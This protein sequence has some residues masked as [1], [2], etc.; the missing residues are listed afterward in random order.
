M[1]FQEDASPGTVM[2]V[3]VTA[4]PA[5]HNADIKQLTIF[6]LTVTIDRK[7]PVKK[8]DLENEDLQKENWPEKW[9]L[10]LIIGA[11]TF[12][13]LLVALIVIC[14][15]DRDSRKRMNRNRGAGNQVQR[16][17]LDGVIVNKYA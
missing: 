5:S 12:S 4:T 11:L 16:D 2:E 9:Q 13:T 17:N 3:N 1:T 14:L 6:S 8:D 10:G 7:P 15:L